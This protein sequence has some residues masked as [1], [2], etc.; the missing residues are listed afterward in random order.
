M[1]GTARRLT[2]TVI[3]AFGTCGLARGAAPAPPSYVAIEQTIASLRKSWSGPGGQPNSLEG[4]W[5]T[6]FDSL[7]AELKAYTKAGSD[8][9]RVA[10]MSKLQQISAALATAQWPPAAQ[11]NEELKEWLEPRVRFDGAGRRMSEA[12]AALPATSDASVR[13]N[14]DR[15][16]E[17]AQN[18]LGHALRDYDAATTVAQRQEALHR[19]HESFRAL[20]EKNRLQPWA[21]SSE[22]EAVVSE[23]FNQPNLEI[24]ADVP[25]VAPVFERNLVETGPVTRKGYLSQVTAGPKTG[26]GLLASDDGIAFF[27]RQTYVSVTPIWDFQN[28]IASDQ[29]GQRAAKLYLF[30]ATTVDQAELT[31][32]TVLK[33]SGLEISPSWT[34]AIDTSINSAPTQGADLGRAIACMIGMGQQAI[35]NKVY[36]GSIGRFREQIPIESREEGLERIAVEQEQRN[37]DLKSKYLVGNRSA[38]IRDLLITDLV[39]R[40]RPEA[41]FVAGVLNWRS[42]PGHLGAD[43]PQPAT[44]TNTIEPGVTADVHVGSLLSSLVSGLYGRDEVQSVQNLM[45]TIRPVPPGTPP[46]EGIKVTKNVDF[47]TFA[48]AVDESRKPGADKEKSAVLRITR[49]KK[50]PEFTTDARGFLVALIHDLQIDVPAPE[51][52]AKGGIVGAPAK[53][54]RIKIP[55]AEVSLSYKLDS[56]ATGPP[57]IHAKAEEFNPGS[58]AEV[59]AIADDENKGMSLSRF[60]A[61]IVMGAMGGR[62]R[63]QSFEFA[64]DQLNL[65]GV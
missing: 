2:A 23:L 12:I 37:A 45:L 46:R 13:A 43:L 50:P 29:R 28:Q 31:I 65:P 40:S 63:T 5:N 21:P 15:W 42:A 48:K 54:Y 10:A 26:F 33:P 49:P 36:E 62:L 51:G 32:T 3:L 25:T 52:E 41:A 38:A 19:I 16:I 58:N 9:D 22:L 20:S 53:I 30:S 60:S 7:L 61:G 6:L 14:R 64:L 57:R 18:D 1:R 56:P 59:L 8:P 24:A 34:H 27:N 47:A 11:L 35:T 39:L 44:L 4:S 17:F 55:L